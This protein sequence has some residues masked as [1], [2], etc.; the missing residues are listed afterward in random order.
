LYVVLLILSISI[1]NAVWLLALM[2]LLRPYWLSSE[3]LNNTQW[4]INLQPYL[5]ETRNW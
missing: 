2:S 3:N 1:T 4:P 5:L